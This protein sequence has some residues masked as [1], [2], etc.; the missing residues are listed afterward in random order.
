MVGIITSDWS[1]EIFCPNYACDN[2]TCFTEYQG[3]PYL[4]GYG[5]GCAD[6]MMS[7]GFN[8][9]QDETVV[10]ALE[11]LNSTIEYAG[12]YSSVSNYQTR[13]LAYVNCKDNWLYFSIQG[14]DVC[15][16]ELH[17][18][19]GYKRSWKS[20][21]TDIYKVSVLAYETS[22][23]VEQECTEA[24]SGSDVNECSFYLDALDQVRIAVTN[25]TIVEGVGS[26]SCVYCY[27][28]YELTNSLV[29]SNLMFVWLIGFILWLALDK[30]SS[31][32][33]VHDPESLPL[34]SE[35]QG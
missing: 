8:L 1:D 5:T 25:K 26:F 35:D 4:D 31:Y 30:F 15:Q 28:W 18:S 2:Y 6:K 16:R 34:S 32:I 17:L 3:D 27:G 33:K 9:N 10:E 20:D 24:F 29:L 7:G 13:D 12:P 22:S 23:L 11:G 19:A 21:I 14:S